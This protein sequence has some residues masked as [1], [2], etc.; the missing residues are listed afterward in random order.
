MENKYVI[1]NDT[2][3]TMFKEGYCPLCGS[4]NVDTNNQVCLD[5]QKLSSENE[6][7]PARYLAEIARLKKLLSLCEYME[8]Q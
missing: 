1:M 8:V 4:K 7:D 6:E 3:K 2:I 5:C